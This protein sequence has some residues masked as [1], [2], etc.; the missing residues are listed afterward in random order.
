[1]GMVKPALLESCSPKEK[2]SCVY[3][4]SASVRKEERYVGGTVTRK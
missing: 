2:H 3:L 4:T 1:M